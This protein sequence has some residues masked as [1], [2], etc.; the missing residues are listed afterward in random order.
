MTLD[1]SF[2]AIGAPDAITLASGLASPHNQLTTLNLKNT[3]IGTE[4]ETGL[5]ISDAGFIAR[6]NALR[7]GNSHLSSLNLAANPSHEATIIALANA[8]RDPNHPCLITSLDLSALYLTEVA[9]RALA[10]ALLRPQ[11][12]RLSLPLADCG[13]ERGGV[14]IF[15]QVLASLHHRLEGLDLSHNHLQKEGARALEQ[16]LRANPY[17]LLRKLD[18]QRNGR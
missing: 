10:N 2:H 17:S 18:L 11:Q 16:A 1:L 14:I 9:M 12:R 8:F 3:G 5:V 7:S 15:A 6:A 13:L 4:V